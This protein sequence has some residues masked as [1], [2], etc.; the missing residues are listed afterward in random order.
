MTDAE[1]EKMRKI[2]KSTSSISSLELPALA[3]A[4]LAIIPGFLDEILVGASVVA[5]ISALAL[6]RYRLVKNR[7]KYK[8]AIEDF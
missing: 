5:F 8:E 1:F 3:L 6:G 4:A 2:L 7:T